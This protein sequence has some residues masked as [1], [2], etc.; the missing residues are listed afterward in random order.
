MQFKT[1]IEPFRIKMVEPLTLTT[2]EQRIQ[3]LKK[4]HYNPF[5]L[6]AEHVLIDLLTDSGTS[7]M[8]NKQWA[9]MIMGDESY[10]GATSWNHMYNTVFDLTGME[11]VLPTHQG[12][13]AER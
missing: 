9:G 1:I 10:A 7:A 8:S 12:R 6:N 11:H 3:Y 2:E 13:A 5:T 4:A